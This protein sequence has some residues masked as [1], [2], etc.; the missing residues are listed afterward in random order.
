MVGSTIVRVSPVASVC[1]FAPVESASAQHMPVQNVRVPPMSCRLPI[2]M[3]SR[4]HWQ[5]YLFIAG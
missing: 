1:A 2:P 3:N 4:R 5:R